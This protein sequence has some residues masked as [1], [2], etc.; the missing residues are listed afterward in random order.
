MLPSILKWEP[1]DLCACERIPLSPFR[2]VHFPVLRVQ[3]SSASVCSV[4]EGVVVRGRGAEAL[5]LSLVQTPW[6]G[7]GRHHSTP[8]GGD[9]GPRGGG[10]LG[11][12]AGR[13]PQ[14]RA[15]APFKITAR[16][17]PSGPRSCSVPYYCGVSN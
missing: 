1:T 4:L 2:S 6:R 15:N 14:A 11:A 5:S 7:S 8:G 10:R 3:G 17:H 16:A 9:A 13:E 12:A